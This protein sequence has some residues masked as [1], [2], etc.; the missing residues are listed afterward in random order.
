[1]YTEYRQNTP[2]F[3]AVDV[4]G[5]APLNGERAHRDFRGRPRGRFGTLGSG[6]GLVRGRPRRFGSTQGAGATL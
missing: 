6:N 3:T 1:M 4:T 2:L 5:T